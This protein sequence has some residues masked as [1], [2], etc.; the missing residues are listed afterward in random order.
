M[1]ETAIQWERLLTLERQKKNLMNK[2]NKKIKPKEWVGAPVAPPL[3]ERKQR[4]VKE[5]F[6]PSDR[7]LRSHLR[8]KS[9]EEQATD[10]KLTTDNAIGSGM[11]PVRHEEL[12]TLQHWLV[13]TPTVRCLH[14]LSRN[15]P[16]ELEE[17]L[18]LLNCLRPL[19]VA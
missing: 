5:T 9:D 6:T 19:M 12:K 1:E 8:T 10:V 14:Y 7:V 3:C 2:D 13:T 16:T 4:G 18:I 17:I 15:H 11:K